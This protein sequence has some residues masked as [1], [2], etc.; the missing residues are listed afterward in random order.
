MKLGYVA[1]S[2]F[3]KTESIEP[4]AGSVFY[5]VCLLLG[6]LVWSFGLVWF[7][8]AV[9]SVIRTRTFPFNLGWWGFTFPIGVFATGTC[10][11]GTELPST[12][13]NV[14]GTIFSLCVVVLWVI[15]TIGTIRAVINGSVFYAPAL[16][17]L[18]AKMKTDRDGDSES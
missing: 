7:V 3:P 4:S 15:V 11:L 13:F 10:Q 16:E 14:L 1:K 17:E 12:V 5:S 9:A 6:L 8:F 2:V 18:D